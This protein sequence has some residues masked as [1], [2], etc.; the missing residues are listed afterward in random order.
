MVALQMLMTYLPGMNRL[1]GTAPFPAEEWLW[2]ILV[3]VVI[4]VAVE[5]EK[6]IRRRRAGPAERRGGLLACPADRGAPRQPGDRKAGRR[7]AAGRFRSAG[8]P[9][10]APAVSR[11]SS[12]ERQSTAIITLLALIT[13]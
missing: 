12:V 6:W 11:P 10:A 2:I 7:R 13:A 1:F 3:G 8:R 5:M 4:H 9:K